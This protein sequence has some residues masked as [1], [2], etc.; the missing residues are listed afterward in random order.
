MLIAVPQAMPQSQPTQECDTGYS[1][2][3][4]NEIVYHTYIANNDTCKGGKTMQDKN[5][6]FNEKEK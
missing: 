1:V 5:I 3:H 4:E 2:Q 6:N